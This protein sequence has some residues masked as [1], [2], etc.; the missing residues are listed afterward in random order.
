M[1]EMV[2]KTLAEDKKLLILAEQVAIILILVIK[3]KEEYKLTIKTELILKLA[4][5]VNN[6]LISQWAA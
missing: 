6:H 3:H 1:L 5:K 2:T 4:I